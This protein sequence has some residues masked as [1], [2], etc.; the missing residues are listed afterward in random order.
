MENLS[1]KMN[2]RQIDTPTRQELY[3][4]WTTLLSL[5]LLLLLVVGSCVWWSGGFKAV[6]DMMLRFATDLGA[7]R[8]VEIVNFL[9]SLCFPFLLTGGIFLIGFSANNR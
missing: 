9:I 8:R 3:A 7:G 6:C 1:K 5:S 2:N 4:R